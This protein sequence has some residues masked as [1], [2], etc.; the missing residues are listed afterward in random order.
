MRT[1]PILNKHTRQLTENAGLVLFAHML[2]PNQPI[3]RKMY[4]DL[5]ER[6]CSLA[7]EGL[8]QEEEYT[9]SIALNAIIKARRSRTKAGVL[10]GVI[11]QKK[12][13]IF[14]NCGDAST[15]KA[16]WLVGKETAKSKL[17]H[18][19]DEN[20]RRRLRQ[21]YLNYADVA[22]L[23]AAWKTMSREDRNRI[24]GAGLSWDK[25][26]LFEF[27]GMASWFQNQ[28]A[29]M[30]ESQSTSAKHKMWMVPDVFFVPQSAV[31]VPPLS[32][33]DR[34]ELKAYNSTEY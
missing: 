13:Q 25:P 28:I 34:A 9:R 18:G 10:A 1:L 8:G 32:T 24:H 3:D 23:W 22:H 14:Q 33:S 11:L 15:R 30:E 5:P 29:P 7:L 27:L 2:F 12:I 20:T 16:I 4:V 21:E 26:M 6:E 19:E 31:F 17:T